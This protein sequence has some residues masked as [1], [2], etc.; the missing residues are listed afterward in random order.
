MWPSCHCVWLLLLRQPSQAVG[1]FG[2]SRPGHVFCS[3]FGCKAFSAISG[4]CFGGEYVGAIVVC[5]A[6]RCHWYHRKLVSKCRR[7][8]RK[9]VHCVSI[10]LWVWRGSYFLCCHWRFKSVDGAMI[11]CGAFVGAL[12]KSSS[13]GVLRESVW[14]PASRQSHERF[15]VKSGRECFE[16]GSREVFG[17]C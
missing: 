5:C 7:W 15:F 16:E 10:G 3:K 17:R 6:S 9:A 2:G 1:Q 11:V 13:V 8:E 4:G 14:R 12:R